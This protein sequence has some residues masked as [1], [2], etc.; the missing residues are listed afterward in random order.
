MSDKNNKLEINKLIQRLQE[1]QFQREDINCE[2]DAIQTQLLTL[3]SERRTTESR[4]E[5]KETSKSRRD[6]QGNIIEIG[7]TVK[8][9]TPTKFKGSQGVVSSFSPVRVT[10]VTKDK[11]KVSKNSHNLSVIKKRDSLTERIPEKHG[12]ESSFKKWARYG[13]HGTC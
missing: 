13:R 6:R 4:Q 1:I 2:E 10:S 9:L 12:D 7:D 3:S 8:F 11:R 5:I